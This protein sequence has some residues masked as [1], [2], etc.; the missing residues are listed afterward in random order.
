MKS[1]RRCRSLLGTDCL[2]TLTIDG[3]TLKVGL[4][5][6]ENFGALASSFSVPLARIAAVEAVDDPWSVVRGMRVGTG[7][8]WLILLG[9]MVRFG[10]TPNDFVAI[11]RRRPAVVVT[12]RP[13]ASFGRL[14]V[15][16][17]AAAAFAETLRRAAKIDAHGISAAPA[18]RPPSL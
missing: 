9:T 16:V 11:Y 6:W 1:T 13:Q 12:L 7:F 10:S 4:S 18:E 15:T 2:A 14:I 5:S 8:P 17:P 3:D